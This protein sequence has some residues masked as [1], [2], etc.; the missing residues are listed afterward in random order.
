MCTK[1][2]TSSLDVTTLTNRFRAESERTKF[3][4]GLQE[5]L[6]IETVVSVFLGRGREFEFVYA[7]SEIDEFQSFYSVHVL[8]NKIWNNQ[9]AFSLF[10]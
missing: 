1:Q 3:T 4:C 6:T 5:W 7:C 8:W 2:G 10:F 9:N